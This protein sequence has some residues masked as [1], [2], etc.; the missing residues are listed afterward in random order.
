[1]VR[2]K[3]KSK[4]KVSKTKKKKNSKNKCGEISFPTVLKKIK[5]KLIRSKSKTA[6]DAIFAA[7]KAAHQEKKKKNGIK[8]SRIIKIPKSG[9]ILPLIPIFAGLSALGALSGGVG[10]IAKAIN[11]AKETRKQL[12]ESQRHN[13]TMEAIAMGK[14]LFLKP[15]K[16]GLGLF[17]D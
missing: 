8:P 10:G 15:Y 6:N 4:K 13:K 9:G 3:R 2:I 12:E 17:L 11:S 1:M 14:G 7:L 16:K 5:N